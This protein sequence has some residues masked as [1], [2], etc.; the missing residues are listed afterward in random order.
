M[1][2]PLFAVDRID[3]WVLWF[4]IAV[5]LLSVVGLVVWQ[6]AG[7]LARKLTRRRAVRQSPEPSAPPGCASQIKNDPERLK[8]ACAA[9]EARLAQMYLELAEASMQRGEAEQTAAALRKIVR[10]CPE[11]RQAQEARDRLQRLGTAEDPS[12]G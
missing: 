6:L 5:A 11:T 8:Q 12:E 3:I 1:T 10:M 4:S 9:Q 2:G 7:Y